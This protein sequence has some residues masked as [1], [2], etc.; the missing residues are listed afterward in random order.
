M[1]IDEMIEAQMILFLCMFLWMI[2]AIASEKELLELII[3][4]QPG[5]TQTVL[6]ERGE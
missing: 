6:K 5:E 3:N 2:V 4:L 1:S